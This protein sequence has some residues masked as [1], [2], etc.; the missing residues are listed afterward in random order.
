MLTIME[1][2]RQLLLLGL[3]LDETKCLEALQKVRLLTGL[4]GRWD[5]LSTMPKIIADVA[6]NEAGLS[7]SIRQLMK[8]SPG[9]LHFVLGFVQDK[10]LQSILRLFPENA[11]YYF[12]R[13]DIP[14]GLNA[15]TLQMSAAEHGLFGKSYD[16]VS[17]AYE[18]AKKN[19]IAPD[20]IY[21]GGSTFVVAEII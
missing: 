2:K 17:L 7:C 21:V 15:E 3:R 1:A 20:T 19:A 8:D 13:P 14:R 10:D 5:I 9:Q 11:T 6:H 16:S 4:R 18:A 12:C